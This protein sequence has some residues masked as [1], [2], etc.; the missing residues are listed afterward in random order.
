[1]P[2]YSYAARSIT[3]GETVHHEAE[4]SSPEMLRDRLYVEGQQM[5]EVHLVQ[6]TLLEQVQDFFM[7]VPIDDLLVFIR[8]LGTLIRAGIP[9]FKAIQIVIDQ[10]DEPRLKRIVTSLK[11]DLSEGSS[12]AKAM[13]VFPQVFS[14][15]MINMV[16]VGESRGQLDEAFERILVFEEKNREIR[17]KVV[18]ALTYPILLLSVGSLVLVAMIVFVLPKFVQIFQQSNIE[19]PLATRILVH[20]SNF[21]SNYYLFMLLG[22]VSIIFGAIFFIQ[23]QEGRRLKDLF[24]FKMPIFG[25][26]IHHAAL[27]RFARTLG[28]LHKSGVPLIRS[29]ELSRDAL[30][31]IVMAEAINTVIDS[32]RD[33]KGIA[34]P[35]SQS[36]VFPQ[37][38]AHMIGVGEES[39]TLDDMALKAS[40]FYDQETEYKI[41]RQMTLLEPIALIFIALI[42]MFIAASILLP[43]FKMAG[44]LRRLG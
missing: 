17:N 37:I 12:L 39:G 38:M 10:T 25:T 21:V 28:I 31:N 33:G 1:M 36:G 11:N 13:T 34:E 30:N 8:Q 44:S 6:R 22:I 5:L 23:T 16:D 43:M 18:S 42:V 40:D 19:L 3:T 26:V 41:K 14:P 27:S 29:L 7:R 32:V 15:F 4:A 24:K 35:L 2:K 9:L 20:V